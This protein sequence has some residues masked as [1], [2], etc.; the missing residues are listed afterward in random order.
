VSDYQG[1]RLLVVGA[2][3]S[4]GESIAEEAVAGGAR[5]AIAA[6][7]KDKLDAIADR[8]GHGTVSISADCTVADDCVAVVE[9]AV[10]ALGGLD[11]LVYTP[12]LFLLRELE[13]ITVDEWRSI[14]DIN[15]IG[16]ALVTSAALQH[17]VAARGRAAYFSSESTPAVPHWPGLASYAVTKVA[18]D[19][20]ISCWRSERPEVGFTM[21]QVG[22]TEG[23]DG[24]NHGG[25][26]PE[27]VGRFASK[28]VLRAPGLQPRPV[29]ARA[30]L[31]ALA[32]PSYVEHIAIGPPRA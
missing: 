6:R 17:L 5:V 4:I 3:V 25:W 13:E 30:V 23:S 16:A 29:V 32:S 14:L 2:S 12:A 19:K 8:L 31:D 9:H 18:L 15:L 1:K 27:Q 7:R 11:W 10:A 26:T 28:W 24:P 22:S 21:V 20:L